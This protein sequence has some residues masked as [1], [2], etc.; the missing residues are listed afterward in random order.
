MFGL[1]LLPAFS[2]QAVI[3]R[4]FSSLRQFPSGRDPA[5]SLQPV[6]RR[7]QR[8]GFD[9]EQVV[10]SSLDVLGDGVPMRSSQKQRAQD[11]EVESPLQ[12]IYA[13]SRSDAQSVDSLLFLV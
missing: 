10:G 1:Q 3:F 11:Q 13:R 6:Q 7:I 12:E 8:S 9:L 5:A 4:S 2:R